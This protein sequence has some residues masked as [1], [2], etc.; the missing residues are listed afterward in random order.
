MAAGAAVSVPAVER[1]P[2]QLPEALQL[3]ASVDDHDNVAALPMTTLA[4]L[5][6]SVTVGGGGVT[7]RVA[8]LVRVPPAP[9]QLSVYDSAP[10]LAGVTTVLPLSARAPLQ[11]PVAV[12]E[13]ALIEDQ[14]SVAVLPRTIAA[15][16][17]VMVTVGEARVTVT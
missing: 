11:A 7:V 9:V 4:G 8:L 6:P 1:K 2:V 5:T 14:L 12:Q 15:G 3:V 16:L 10:T 13:D 17:T